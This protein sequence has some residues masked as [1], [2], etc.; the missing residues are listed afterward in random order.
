MQFYTPEFKS[1]LEVYQLLDEGSKLQILKDK[2]LLDDYTAET[3]D[4]L[5]KGKA[6]IMAN[7]FIE[8]IRTESLAQ[9]GNTRDFTAVSDKTGKRELETATRSWHTKLIGIRDWIDVGL[10]GNIEPYKNYTFLQM[11]HAAEEWHDS[12]ESGDGEV[13]Y[14]EQNPI[15]LDFRDKTTGL[16]FYWCDLQTSN[17]G[18]ESDRMGHCGRT[19]AETL[20]SL[21][22]YKKH[23]N[24]T[25]LNQSHLTAA[26]DY[27]GTMYQMKGPHN[28]KPE[29][30]YHP[31]I[32]ALIESGHLTDIKSEYDSGSDFKLYDLGKDAIEKLYKKMPNAKLFNTRQ[33]ARALRQLGIIKEIPKMPVEVNE[34]DI[35]DLLNH[36]LVIFKNLSP[37]NVN[38]M[39]TGENGRDYM[40]DSLPSEEDIFDNFVHPKNK[41]K[42]EELLNKHL[43]KKGITALEVFDEVY[44]VPVD[45]NELWEVADK[46]RLYHFNQVFEYANYEDLLYAIR[47]AYVY[48]WESAIYDDIKE[49]IIDTLKTEYNAKNISFDQVTRT[50]YVYPT[51]ASRVLDRSKAKQVIY[52]QIVISFQID[53]L[54]EILDEDTIDETID[55]WGSDDPFDILV[56]AVSDGAIRPDASRYEL[57]DSEPSKE[58]YNRQLGAMLDA[59]F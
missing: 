9:N 1:L 51:G 44:P 41:K 31:Y 16:G 39:L 23:I 45:I 46:S 7:K 15:I 40:F 38:S 58:E 3:F 47:D 59:N 28:S 56:N 52:K 5:F 34:M 48:A 18:E 12:L 30:Q 50:K 27:D 4:T 2:L 21:R 8:Y 20:Y 32:V 57:S 17:C 54:N 29:K 11:I 13:N 25:T 53:D 37:E 22:E 14:K 42:I 55:Y 35:D 33:G 10:N 26:M 6:V 19:G 43:E 49:A 36:D 24:N